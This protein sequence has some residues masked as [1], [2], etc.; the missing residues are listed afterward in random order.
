MYAIVDISG[1]QFQV[2]KGQEIKVPFS[3]GEV[4]T[5][6][7]LERVLLVGEDAQTHIGQPLVAGASIDATILNHGRER[8]VT[9]FKFKRRKGYRRTRGHRQDYTVL[10]IN[11]IKLGKPKA[12]QADRTAAVTADP[13][14]TKSAK[15]STA[16]PTAAKAKTTIHFLILHRRLTERDYC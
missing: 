16:K 9:V 14:K 7:Q 13:S 5:N 15:K 10:R 4:G 8:K 6:L 11:D 3:S 2:V 12:T 1:S